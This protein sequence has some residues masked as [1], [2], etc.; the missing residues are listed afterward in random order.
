[1]ALKFILA[2]SLLAWAGASTAAPDPLARLAWLQGCW[3]ASGGAEPG[4]GEQWTSSS[5]GAMLGMGR[6]VRNGKMLDF[7]FFQIR[8]TAPGKL[9]YI[10][11]PGGTPATTFLLIR[12]DGIEF[13]FENL[14]HDFPQRIVYRRAGETAM[15]ARIEGTVKGKA[16]GIDF[17]MKRIS[18]TGPE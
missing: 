13:V 15:N 4:S 17:P 2:S 6:T 18:C 9:A 7:E 12:D 16:K 10:A 11:Q 14:A 5:G 3:G 1:M 8:E